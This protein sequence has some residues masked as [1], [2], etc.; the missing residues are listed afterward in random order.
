MLEWLFAPID[1]ERIH[2]VDFFI[3]WHGRFM[4]MAW[5][6]LIPIGII[7]AR[8]FKVLPSQNW[9]Q[10]LDNQVWWH[11]HRAS[12]YTAAVA[13]ALATILILYRSA[14]LIDTS[15]H[16]RIGWVVL[17]LALIQI[18]SGIFRGTK[19]GPTDPDTDKSLTGDHFDMTR[20]RII[21]EYY[22]KVMGYLLLSM[23]IYCILTGMWIANAPNWMWL[24]L[25]AWW[26]A[27]LGIS[28]YL[29]FRGA[30]FDTYKAIWGS[31]ENLTGNQRKPIGIGINEYKPWS[32]QKK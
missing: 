24:T 7:V 18:L 21:F 1:P 8:F 9:P 25:I 29:Q 22:H 19:G 14:T 20:R 17:A 15:F 2:Q 23:A 30:C 10:Q 12:Q 6:A 5:G 32:I 16:T 31:A 11:T 26:I 4:A 13:M 3:S 28:L 27:L